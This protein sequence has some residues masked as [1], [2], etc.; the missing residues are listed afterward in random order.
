MPDADRNPAQ[1]RAGIGQQRPLF[2]TVSLP[3]GRSVVAASDALWFMSGGGVADEI[4][5][6]ALVTLRLRRLVQTEPI[7]IST[8]VGTAPSPELDTLRNCLHKSADGREGQGS[9]QG[10]KKIDETSIAGSLR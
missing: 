2:E 1:S 5:S 3:F 7:G 10:V 6:G 4:R 9:G 8:R